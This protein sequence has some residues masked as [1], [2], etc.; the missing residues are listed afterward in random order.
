MTIKDDVVRIFGE[1]PDWT[2]RQIA[3]HLTIDRYHVYNTARTEGLTLVS[4]HQTPPNA[5]LPTTLR[6][7]IDEPADFT[8]IASNPAEMV[9]AQNQMIQWVIDKIDAEK[10]EL[11]EAQANLRAALESGWKTTGWPERVNKLTAKIEFYRKMRLALDAGY[12]IVPPFPVDIFAIRVNRKSPREKPS[13]YVHSQHMQEAQLLPAGEGSYVSPL[14]VAYGR[15]IEGPEKD[16]KPTR[17]TE[18]FAKHWKEAEFPF[19][20]AKGQ[21]MKAAQAAMALKVFDQIGAL[22]G[23]RPPD[24]IICGQ[25]LMPHRGRQPLNFF[26][27]WWLDTATL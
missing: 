26:V 19:K 25:I 24:P 2:A 6:A 18:Y 20:L 15:S 12:Y 1:H 7:A 23:P 27:A 13:T 16:G 5:L 22:P 11:A 21:I 4:G 10:L 8:V 3:E 9:G 14:P 17:V